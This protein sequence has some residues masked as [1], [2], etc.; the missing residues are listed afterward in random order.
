MEFYKELDVSR[1]FGEV[2][3]FNSYFSN[4]IGEFKGFVF[5]FGICLLVF[6][7]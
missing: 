1:F 6:F 4:S 5:E 2:L 3:E 7:R